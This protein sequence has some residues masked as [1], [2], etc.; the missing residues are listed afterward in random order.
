[1]LIFNRLKLIC[2][3][4][5]I[6]NAIEVKTSTEAAINNILAKVK[7]NSEVPSLSNGQSLINQNEFIVHQTQEA[8]KFKRSLILQ[9][10]SNK[11]FVAAIPKN[12]TAIK[13]HKKAI[14]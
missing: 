11:A 3:F 12:A 6:E 10:L 9:S 1:M 7:A 8:T 13:T 14:P 4:S 5:A 2:F